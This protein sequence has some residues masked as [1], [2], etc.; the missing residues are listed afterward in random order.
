M[1]KRTQKEKTTLSPTSASRIERGWR[2]G[3]EDRENN[4]HPKV[5]TELLTS[6]ESGIP[7]QLTFAVKGA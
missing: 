3:K 4:P 5:W 2:D 7:A 1:E 6:S